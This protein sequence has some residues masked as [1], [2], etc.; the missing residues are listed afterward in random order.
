[1]Q[2]FG[3]MKEPVSLDRV[4]DVVRV[5][6]RVFRVDFVLPDES[7]QKTLLLKVDI[8]MH[9]HMTYRLW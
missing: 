3:C 1:M 9:M 6:E 2:A 5:K 4:V 8:C 7:G